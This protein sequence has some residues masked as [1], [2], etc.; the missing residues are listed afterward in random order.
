VEERDRERRAFALDHFQ[1]NLADPDGYDL[2]LNAIRFPAPECA[3]IIVTTLALL[4]EV[5]ATQK[6]E[7][8]TSA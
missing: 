2:L 1:K 8:G 5:V 4:R 3:E 6:A 7:A